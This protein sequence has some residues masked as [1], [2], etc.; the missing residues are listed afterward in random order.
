MRINE[1]VEE[2]KIEHSRVDEPMQK[3]SERGKL[4]SRRQYVAS[5]QIGVS[6]YID[7]IEEKD[8]Q[9]YPVEYKKGRTGNWLNDKVQL[10]SLRSAVYFVNRF[11]RYAVWGSDRQVRTLWLYLLYQ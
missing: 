7:L 10:C 1:H 9:L 2:G 5:M 11:T 3:R 8:D 4:M 6:G